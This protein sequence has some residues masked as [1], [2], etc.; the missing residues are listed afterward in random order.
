MIGQAMWLQAKKCAFTFDR[1]K[2]I[3]DSELMANILVTN[4]DGVQAPGIFA[5]AKA[6]EELGHVTV[7]APERNWSAAGHP[8]TLHKPLRVQKITWPEGRTAYACSGA[9]SDCVALAL[10]GAV[11]GPFDLVVSGIN[12]GFNLGSDVI[13]SGTVAGA[14]EAIITGVPAI[15]VSMGRH[16]D[17]GATVEEIERSLAHAAAVAVEVT[18]NALLHGLPELTMLNVNIPWHSATDY[19]GIETTR[20]GRRVYRDKL[21]ERDDPW[22]RPYYWIGGE[23]PSGIPD[24]GTDIG[25]IERG[26]VSV[27]PLG[28]DLTRHSAL[29]ALQEWQMALAVKEAGS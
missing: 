11:Q 1:R 6:L 4:D 17:G 10:M 28:I 19:R 13:Y 26:F 7:V 3:D 14:M 24:D 5:L 23:I 12:G 16:P 25:A 2:R 18:R 27:T 29:T 9:P 21:I 8:K 22:G 20:L 15:A